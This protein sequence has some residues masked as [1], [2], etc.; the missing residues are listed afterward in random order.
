MDWSESQKPSNKFT[1]FFWTLLNTIKSPC[2]CVCIT[3]RPYISK[4]RTL[5][6]WVLSQQKLLDGFD[7]VLIQENNVYYGLPALLAF[8][9][10]FSDV[11]KKLLTSH[12][13][14]AKFYFFWKHTTL[15]IFFCYSTQN[16]CSSKSIWRVIKTFY[17]ALY[18]K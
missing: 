18:L 15:Q 3:Y 4:L 6:A 17:N 7:V 1:S 14:D 11:I 10:V 5:R 9:I 16:F 8:I 13:Q 12:C 2:V